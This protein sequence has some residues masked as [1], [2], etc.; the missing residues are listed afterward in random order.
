MFATIIGAV[1]LLDII[2]GHY[3]YW[4]DPVVNS[5]NVLTAAIIVL[6]VSALLMFM[7]VRIEVAK[8][9]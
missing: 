9:S 5:P 6:L 4:L 3:K 7:L 2:S 1:A 8:K